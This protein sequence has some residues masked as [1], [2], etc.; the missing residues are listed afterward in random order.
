MI[1]FTDV[2]LAAMSRRLK[3]DMSD[4][5]GAFSRARKKLLEIKAWH[6]P[7]MRKTLHSL[8]KQERAMNEDEPAKPNEVK[9]FEEFRQEIGY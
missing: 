1:L 4:P 3:G 8:L 6:T 5:T 7:A 9:S 2:E